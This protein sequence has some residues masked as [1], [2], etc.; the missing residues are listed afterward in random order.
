MSLVHN[1]VIEDYIQRVTELGQSTQ[2]LPTASELE[3]IATELG[4]E[5]AEIQ[6]AQRESQAH[7]TRAQGYMRL[8]YWDD[9]IAEL[10]EAIAFNPGQPEMLICLGQAHLGRWQQHHQQEDVDQLHLRVRQCLSLQPDS[11]A[12]LTLLATFRKFQQN[13]TQLLATAGIFLGAILCGGLGFLFVRGGLPFVIQERSR[14][15]NLEQ[16]LQQQR[17]QLDDLRQEQNQARDTLREELQRQQQRDLV[18]YGDRLNRLQSELNTLKKQ[19]QD[20]QNQAPPIP[21]PSESPTP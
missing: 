8:K 4:I 7:Y 2:R 14:L 1:G 18:P 13:R 17:Q 10:R 15:E 12:A 9:A 16:Q 20:Q 3:A 11:E 5:P 21:L 19:V 6:A